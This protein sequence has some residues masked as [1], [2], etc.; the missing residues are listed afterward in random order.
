MKMTSAYANKMLKKLTEDKSY[1][2][3]KEDLGC[4]YRAAAD[5]EPV[6]PG[7]DFTVVSGEIQAIDEKILKIKHAINLNN[8]NSCITVGDTQM[9]VDEILVAMAQLNRRKQFLDEARK[10]DP[11]KRIGVGMYNPRRAVPEYEYIN[12]DLELVKQEYDRVD[13]QIAQ[14]QIALDRYNQTCEFEVQI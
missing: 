14:M 7:Y 8:V 3:E 4:V 6:I 12:Y 10:R 9:S 5:E 1:W 11:K 13:M 2:K